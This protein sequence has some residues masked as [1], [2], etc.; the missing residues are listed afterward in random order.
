M[1]GPEGEI[2]EMSWQEQEGL[3]GELIMKVDRGLAGWIE[4]RVE[5]V[6]LVELGY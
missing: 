4:V 2:E 1:Y 5:R 3:D 6:E